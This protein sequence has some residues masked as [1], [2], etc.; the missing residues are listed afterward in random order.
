MG[1]QIGD[2]YA[3]KV[4]AGESGWGNF[5]ILRLYGPG[6][7]DYKAAVASGCDNNGYNAVLEGD[8]ILTESEPGNVGNPTMDMLDEYLGYE[9]TDGINDGEEFEW[10]DVPMDWDAVAETGVPTGYNPA[11][12]GARAGCGTDAANGRSGRY[13][14]IPVV[15]D[16]P[17]HGSSAPVEILAI[18]DVYVVGWGEWDASKGTYDRKVAGGHANVYVQFIEEAP[19]KPKDLTGVSDNPLAPLRIMLIR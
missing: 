14:L 18:A 2:I 1:V 12:D 15:D 8:T 5:G 6:K 16:F 17:P 3:V 4:G 7:D 9:L 10:C 11:V 19:F 13:M